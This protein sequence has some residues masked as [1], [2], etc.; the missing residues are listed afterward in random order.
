MLSITYDFDADRLILVF[1]D[2]HAGRRVAFGLRDLHLLAAVVREHEL[3]PEKPLQRRRAI[4]SLGETERDVLKDFVRDE[5]A[6]W[7]QRKLDELY[8][9]AIEV[10][11]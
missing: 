1:P 2:G 7:K 6:K 4:A 9:D 5:V 11:L 10:E 8:A 3:R